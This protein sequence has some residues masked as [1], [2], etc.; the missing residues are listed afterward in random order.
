MILAYAKDAYLYGYL[1]VADS[2]L[3]EY[4]TV[5]LNYQAVP[6][7]QQ[8]DETWQFQFSEM[9]LEIQTLRHRIASHLDYFGNP[10]GWVPMLSFEVNKA[11]YD[12]EIE[13]AVRVLFLSYWIGNAASSV[14]AR[15]S[16][17]GT[18]KDN[19]VADIES[20]KADYTNATAQIPVLK[21]EASAIAVEE[22]QRLQDLKWLE[23]SLEA[24]ASANVEDRNKVPDWKKALGVAS[25]ICKAVPVYQPVLGT[26]GVGLGAIADYDP[27]NPT[28]TAS[29]LGGVAAGFASSAFVESAENW[30]TNANL[31][32]LQ[33]ARTNGLDTYRAYVQN[34]GALA[35]PIGDELANI[36]KILK[37]TEMPKNELDAELAKLEAESPEFQALAAKLKVLA[38][39]KDQFAQDLNQAMQTVTASAAGIT[40]GLLS[41][42][43][44]NR[45][46]AD[47]NRV[48]DQRTVSYLKEMDLRARER[49]LKYHYY[50]AKA[51]EY[52]LLKP[53]P[54]ELNL[55]RLFD[56]MVAMAGAIAATNS[57]HELTPQGFNALEAIYEE[58]LSSLAK[59]IIDDYDNH[60]SQTSF[61]PAQFNLASN[62]LAKLNS[63]QPVTINP[64]QRGLFPL[65][66]ENIRITNLV[67]YAIQTHLTNGVIGNFAYIDLSFAHSG[68]STLASKGEFYFFRHYNSNANGPIRWRTRYDPT[69]NRLDPHEPSPVD[70]SLLKSLLGT[71]AGSTGNLL[72][73]CRPSAWADIVITK[74]ITADTPVDIVVDSLRVELQYDYVD[75]LPGQASLEVTAS[76]SGAKPYIIVGAADLNARQDALGDFDRTYTKGNNVTL[77]VPQSYG[78]WR[79]QKWTDRVGSDLPGGPATNTVLS[80]LL[81][82]NKTLQAQY[83][84]SHTNDVDTDTMDDAWEIKYF[85]ST[86][87]ADQTTD[88]DGDG[89]PDV[90]EYYN[91]TNP[92]VADTDGDGMSDLQ[93]FIAGTNPNDASSKFVV[94]LAPNRASPGSFILSWDSVINRYYRVYTR[95]SLSGVWTDVYDIWGDGTRKSYTNQVPQSPGQFFRLSVELPFGP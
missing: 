30:E 34:L 55:T 68:L 74:E 73:F 75:K 42:D 32:D 45:G 88:H 47:G 59:G 82:D 6:Q 44:M 87:N 70:S 85:G 83:I 72:L 25:I 51:Y 69:I 41:L 61:V 27:L 35:A 23:Q 81:S 48:L 49:L 58:Q 10:A 62:E 54:G 43:A 39:R 8:L 92:L 29:A 77:T 60:P 84:Y 31:I 5:L 90:Q 18:A 13:R 11:A 15:V 79:F 28:A 63:G 22:Q 33:V 46:V 76:G 1:D 53:Y 40:H 3:A 4:E 7:W 9:L 16:A 14:Q 64:Y 78:E 2:T 95:P 91:G 71:T 66:E 26:I 37:G 38:K 50:M 17:L 67:V 20:F 65:S 94:N 56:S 12:L 80:V 36:Q 19:T 52:R 57:N 24:R 89:V 86:T 21:A 93:E